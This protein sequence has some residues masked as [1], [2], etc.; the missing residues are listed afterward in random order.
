MS[1][2]L[3]LTPY[4][5]EYIEIDI[6]G[7]LQPCNIRFAGIRDVFNAYLSTSEP[8]P[9]ETATTYKGQR[10]ITF[11]TSSDGRDTKFSRNSLYLCIESGTTA[12]IKATVAFGP[13]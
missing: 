10:L 2:S 3:T 8:L 1:V 13:D 5:K 12:S 11:S 4:I 7:R 9:D 6:L